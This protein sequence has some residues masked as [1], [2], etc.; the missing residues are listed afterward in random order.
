MAS[1][2]KPGK[3]FTASSDLMTAQVGALT[4]EALT[5]TVD[6]VVLLLRAGNASTP[7]P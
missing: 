7:K 4:T 2:A 3:L 5:Q 6:A 1:Y